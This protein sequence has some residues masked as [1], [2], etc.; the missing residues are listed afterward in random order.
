[1]EPIRRVAVLGSGVMGAG[2]AAHVANGGVPV[3]M[4]DRVPP[5]AGRKTVDRSALAMAARKSLLK[6]KPAPL[7]LASSLDLIDV[8]NFEDDP[9]LLADCDWII[10]AVTEDLDVKR[11]LFAEV[12]K[13]CGPTSLV[14]TNTS[15]IPVAAIAEGMP[16]ELRSRFLGTHFF[17]PPRYLKLLELIPLPETSPE[18]LARVVRFGEDVLGK[19][20][21]YAKDTPNFIANR[22]LTFAMQWILHGMRDAGLT[23]EE[24]DALTG[25]AIGHAKSA[26]FRTADLVGL[27]TLQRVVAN[28]YRRCPED[29]QRGLMQGPA[30]FD[31]LVAKGWLGEKTGSG[32]YKK[33]DARE[34]KGRR[35]ILG[36]DLD[37]LAYRDPVKPRFACIGQA[38]NLDTLAERLRVM[39]FGEDP[40]A[41]F[42]FRLFAHLAQYAG[43]RIPEIADDIV[44][45]D[46]ALKWGFSWETGVFETWDLLGFEAV[47]LRMASEG[48]ELPAIAHALRK[49][50]GTSFYLTEGGVRK[51]FDPTTAAYR[52]VPVHPRALHLDLLRDTPSRVV[53]HNVGC[54]LIDLGDGVLCAAFHTKMNAI[55]G[56]VMAMLSDALDLL[57]ADAFEGLVIGN[58]AP[59]FCVGANLMLVLGSIM[60]GDWEGMGRMVDALQNVGM[61]MKYAAKPVVA[62]PH[63]YALGGGLELCQHVDRCVIAAETYAGLVEAG[64]GVI[65][66]G[67]GSKEMLVRALE[68]VPATVDTDPFPFLRRAFENVAMAK[69]STSGPELIHLGYLRNTDVV[70][71]NFDH[72]LARAK[73]V[74]QALALAGYTPP[75]APRLVALGEPARAAFRV[76]VFGMTESAW[77]S[78]HDALI[79]EKLAH[80]LTGG[81]RLA[82]TKMTEQDVLALEKEAFLSLCGTEKTRARIQ[83]MLANGKPLRN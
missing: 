37:T 49:A 9:H 31:D 29:E 18:T 52:P 19:G 83:H 46:N 11:A 15:G 74:C 65:P 8:G 82:G 48:I 35:V 51:Y 12:A 53:R 64:I 63:H 72:Q 2:I 61:R 38:R 10:E 70:E 30:W 56:E 73:H 77:A 24:V 32:F 13:H 62:A 17:N 33:T 47:C 25:P 54:D 3:L 28:V 43:N 6:S 60:Q 22:L 34:E 20:I 59:H 7:Y 75:K 40:G 5:D 76:V 16:P 78:E 58:Q 57:D 21:V 23:V 26:T 80:V 4:L 27:D 67:G 42:V 55:D 45:I 39:H 50:G 66:A 79:A 69:V 44:N 81:D 71:P 68:C 1:M 41:R 14:S 36:L